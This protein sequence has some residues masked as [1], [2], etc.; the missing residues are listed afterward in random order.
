MLRIN[1]IP[2]PLCLRKVE[3]L[4]DVPIEVDE[5]VRQTLVNFLS[6]RESTLPEDLTLEHKR[7]IALVALY[8]KCPDLI[9]ALVSLQGKEKS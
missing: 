9:D 1:R 8:I 7:Q 4:I 3:N 5:V 2:I 6:H